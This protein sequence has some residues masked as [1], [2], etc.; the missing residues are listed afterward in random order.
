MARS[1]GHIELATYNRLDATLLCFVEE[2]DSP[3][4]VAVIGHGDSWLT[5]LR[6][7]SD[8]I[9]KLVSPIEEAVLGVKMEVNELR[10]VASK[11][12][13]KS[14]VIDPQSYPLRSQPSSIRK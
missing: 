11:E 4:H 6:R 8:N 13:K 10:H 5:E 3:V 14:V 9:F 2:L 1:W 12:R 7:V